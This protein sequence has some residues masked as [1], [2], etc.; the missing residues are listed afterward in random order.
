MLTKI[1]IVCLGLLS[2][3]RACDNNNLQPLE[4]AKASAKWMQ[5]GFKMSMFGNPDKYIPHSMYIGKY[6]V[7]QM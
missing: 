1:V 5:D 7:L 6:H 4:T 2:V 3:G